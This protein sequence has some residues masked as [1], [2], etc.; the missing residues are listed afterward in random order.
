MTK[1]KEIPFL[2]VAMVVAITTEVLQID[3]DIKNCLD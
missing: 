2:A 3:E 1:E